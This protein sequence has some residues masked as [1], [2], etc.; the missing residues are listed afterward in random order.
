MRGAPIALILTL[1]A[2]SSAL[3]PRAG[4][5]QET[6]PASV[7]W[8]YSAYFGTG[9]YRVSGDRN[10]FVVRMTPRWSWSEPSLDDDGKRSVGLY[11]KSPVSLGLDS[12]D[13]DDVLGAVDVDNVSFIS[14]N[15]GIDIEVPVT[16]IWSLRPY[17]SV[18]YGTAFDGSESAWTYW[19]GVKSRVSF[20]SGRL[21][22]HLLNQA[23]FVGYTPNDGPA[24]TIWP[25]MAGLEFDYPVGAPTTDGDQLL[26]HW[27]A[28]YT[29][30]GDDLD[31]TGDPT[32]NQAI[33]DQWEIGAAIARRDS[34]IPIW[35]L[36]FDM[37]GLGYRAS[38]NGELKG[39]TFLFRSMFD[40]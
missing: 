8:A 15:P 22:W 10:V 4:L 16:R 40:L 25:V 35:F 6:P 20:E 28:A 33:N 31:F 13:Y 38:S 3:L 1:L 30:F 27:R 14:V 34:R 5:A 24:D 18:G 9:W 36:D 17:A 32:V 23:G 12:F 37:L 29:L 39:V 21:N 11:F 26:L 2:V 7:H 19:A